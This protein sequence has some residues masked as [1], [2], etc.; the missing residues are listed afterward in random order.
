MQE[1]FYGSYY[2]TISIRVLP[3][4]DNAIKGSDRSLIPQLNLQ[5]TNSNL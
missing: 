1:D 3:A 2:Y 5:N 4:Y